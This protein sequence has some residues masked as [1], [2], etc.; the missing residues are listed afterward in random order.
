MTRKVAIITGSGSGIGA[1]SAVGGV[2]FAAWTSEAI[3][4][5]ARLMP[6]VERTLGVVRIQQGFQNHIPRRFARPLLVHRFVRAWILQKGNVQVVFRAG[7]EQT[8]E[9]VKRQREPHALSARCKLQLNRLVRFGVE[10][11]ERLSFRQL[12]SVVGGELKVLRPRER[13]EQVYLHGGE[14]QVHTSRRS[15]CGEQSNRNSF[16]NCRYYSFS[17]CGIFV[18]QH[19][20]KSSQNPINQTLFIEV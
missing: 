18:G 11:E 19:G 9:F 4:L 20:Y 5:D 3:D 2:V 14:G 10:E 1:A 8:V 6:V 7:H 15:V 12:A 13:P 16:V 17:F